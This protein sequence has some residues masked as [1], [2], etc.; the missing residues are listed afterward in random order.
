MQTQEETTGRTERK[1]AGWM[2]KEYSVWV[3]GIFF[4]SISFESKLFDNICNRNVD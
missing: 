1:R 4:V 2:E 3:G